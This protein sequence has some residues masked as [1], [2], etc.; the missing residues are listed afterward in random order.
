MEKK[1]RLQLL[2][3]I[4]WFFKALEKWAVNPSQYR[5]SH[6]TSILSNL[7]TVRAQLKVLKDDAERQPGPGESLL[8][9]IDA[10]MQEYMALGASVQEAQFRALYDRLLT[11]QVLTTEW[12]ELYPRTLGAYQELLKEKE[13]EESK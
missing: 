13:K 2:N 3:D 11:Y 1:H 9:G 5:K 4:D 10:E 6:Q 7:K 12:N 8:T